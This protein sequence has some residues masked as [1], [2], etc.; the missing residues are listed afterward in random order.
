MSVASTPPSRARAWL[1]AAR[2]ATL[3][4]SVAPVLVGTACAAAA[5]QVRFGPAL[6]AL[7]GAMLIQIGTNLANDFFD[8][9]KGAD[10]AERLGPTRA[11]QAGWLTAA[12]MKRATFLVFALAAAIGAYLIAIGGLPIAL[13]GIASILSGLAYTGGPAPLGYLGLGDVFVFAFFGL[14]AVCGTTFVQLG[15]IPLVAWFAATAVGA[16][17]TAV[18]VVNNLRDRNTDAV[19]HKRTLAV[20]FGRGFAIGEYVALIALAQV[21]TIA[22]AWS[23]RSPLPLVALLTIPRGISLAKQVAGYE[24]RALN[25]LL[26]AT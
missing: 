25:P 16:L 11:V 22:V 8:F 13:L 2:P 10:T 20:R 14:A 6:A 4:A 7:A 3:T 23:L 18:L 5:G 15:H 1:L 19:A 21:A 17:S 12:D 9:E 26:G 24:G